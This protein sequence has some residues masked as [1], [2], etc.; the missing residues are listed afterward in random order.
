MKVLYDTN[1][2]LDV[3]LERKPFVD[4]SSRITGYAEQGV[5]EGWI[6]ATTV[7]TIHYLLTKSLTSKKA[8]YYLKELL[9]IFHVTSVTKTV[10]ENALDSD[11]GDF[12]DSVLH[13]SALHS[14][15]DVIL[16]RNQKNF[17]KS[18]IPVYTPEELLK[19]IKSLE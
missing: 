3:F 1:I 5:L 4:A 15:L 12:E 14:G 18:N 9:K 13:Q 2:L 16:T 19:I 8:K 17:K 7:T 6:C 10:L 11:F